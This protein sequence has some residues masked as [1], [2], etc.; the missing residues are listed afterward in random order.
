MGKSEENVYISYIILEFPQFKVNNVGFTFC[1]E[2]K[3]KSYYSINGKSSF[4]KD[5]W[6]SYIKKDEKSPPS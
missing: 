3:L 1:N 4:F 5:I 2:I 6:G